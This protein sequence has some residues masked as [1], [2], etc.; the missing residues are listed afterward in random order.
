[1]QSSPFNPPRQIQAFLLTSSVLESQGLMG[2][3][4][5]PIPV[6]A[7]R[8]CCGTCFGLDLGNQVLSSSFASCASHS[9]PEPQYPHL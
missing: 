1:M 4:Q 8:K 7:P 6:S 9:L 3:G 2:E 5:H